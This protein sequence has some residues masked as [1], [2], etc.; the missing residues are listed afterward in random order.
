MEDPFEVAATMFGMYTFQLEKGVKTLES[1]DLDNLILAL[2]T[3]PMNPQ[4]IS[5]ENKVRE[6]YDQLKNLTAT[7]AIKTEEFEA[8]VKDLS[9]GEKRRL[10]NAIVQYPL[11]NKDF[12]EKTSGKNLKDC[13]AIGARLME[14][15]T[16]MFIKTL[17][18]YEVSQMEKQN[19]NPVP[20]TVQTN[21]V[22][23]NK[24]DN[25]NG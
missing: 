20:E 22:Q 4:D 23:E 7:K 1:N 6:V 14:A 13:F 12:I 11:A 8:K 10:V 17:S 16:L 18:D 15:K 5:M 9:M 21:N 25:K 2:I 3:Q 24:D 19:Q